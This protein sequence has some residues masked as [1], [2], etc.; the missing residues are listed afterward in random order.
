MW[1]R[2]KVYFL[3]VTLSAFFV[4]FTAWSLLAV[5][6]DGGNLIIMNLRAITYLARS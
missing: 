6:L 2:V 3:V 4:T 1:Q 5:I